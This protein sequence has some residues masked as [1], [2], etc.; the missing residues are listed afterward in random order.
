MCRIPRYISYREGAFL[1]GRCHFYIFQKSASAD[2]VHPPSLSVAP[3]WD[4]AC[5]GWPWRHF[6]KC[7]ICTTEAVCFRIEQA[8]LLPLNTIMCPEVGCPLFPQF[9]TA[10][11]SY[12]LSQEELTVGV[13]QSHGHRRILSYVT[14]L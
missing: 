12:N 8:L 11:A 6:L 13:N 9:L 14:M 1:Q 10:T 2:A 7:Q 5:P 4:C 3:V